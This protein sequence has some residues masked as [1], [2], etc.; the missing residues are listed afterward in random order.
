MNLS[1]WRGSADRPSRR[2]FLAAVPILPLLATASRGSLI[3][4]S[5]A[6]PD[7]GVRWLAFYGE[8][9]DEAV[10]GAYDL[11][12]LDPG[13]QGSISDVKKQGAKVSSYV[14]LGEMRTDHPLFAQLDPDA[15][16]PANPD[17]PGTRRIDVRRASWRSLV[18]EREIPA[19][20]E[21]GF[22]GLMFDTLDT[23]PYLEQLDAVRFRGM[24][25][26]AIDLVRSIRTRWPDLLLI[27]NRGY[28]LLPDVDAHID[29]IVAESLLSS[30][31]QRTGS[32]VW[33]GDR[34]VEAQLALLAAA[35]T[36]ARPLPIFSL[37]YWDPS[38]RKSIAEIYLRERKLGHN[39]Y[40]ATRL[41]DEIIAEP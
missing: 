27:M 15:L 39:P 12:I 8:T 20:L 11:V 14:S 17:W 26:A 25:E 4:S 16:L 22:D 37:D 38:D 24:R 40:V 21:R 35:K 3:T 18:L 36:R 5:F 7:K 29:A 1:L 9:A 30:A 23:P 6:A 19:L 28:A 33:V 31:D 34:E 32:F 10:L 13:Y 2:S 41:L